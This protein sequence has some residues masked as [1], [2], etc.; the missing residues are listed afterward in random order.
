MAGGGMRQSGIIAAAGIVALEQQVERLS[1]D[2]ANAQRLEHGLTSID[3][4]SIDA[5]QTN[6]VFVSITKT[7]AE[8]IEEYMEKRGIIISGGKKI[9]LVTHLDINSA[10]IDTVIEAFKSFVSEI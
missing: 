6:M 9:R 3:E 7:Q 4:L 8:E 2:H 1:E 5:A 10:D